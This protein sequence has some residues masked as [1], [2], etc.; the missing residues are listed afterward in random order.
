MDYPKVC[1]II[2]NWNGYK[3][4]VECLESLQK[5]SYP[6]YKVIVVD[7]GSAEN[8]VSNLRERFG[9]YIHL[10]ENDRNYGFAEGNNIGMR[11]A[12]SNINPGY[13][14]LL[15]NDTV[16]SPDFLTQLVDTAKNQG[17]IGIVGPKIYS[18]NEPN[19]ISFIGTSIDWWHVGTWPINEID[20]G[21]FD[22]VREVDV[23][24]GCALLIKRETIERIGL[25]Y[26]GYFAYFEESEWC[27]QCQKAGYKIVYAPSA[28][29]WHKL[30]AT[31]S[32]AEGLYLY[33]MTRNRFLFMR[34]NATRIRLITFILRFFLWDVLWTT[35]AMLRHRDLKSLQVF[36]NGVIDGIRAMLNMECK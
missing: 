34:R 32:R 24:I 30:S 16:V 20:V 26:A 3:D 19:I 21:Q 25:L 33:Y 35:A 36:Y 7:N 5:I 28:I 6:N 13:I 31:V 14:L 11:Y 23:V 4:T 1:I 8:D 27:I 29:I 2:L 9:D 18:Y 12:L 15:N 10:I 22:E 17:D